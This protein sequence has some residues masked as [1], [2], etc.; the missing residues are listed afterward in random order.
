MEQLMQFAP[1]AIIIV[2]AIVAY[3]ILKNARKK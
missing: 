1:H 3:I 2:L